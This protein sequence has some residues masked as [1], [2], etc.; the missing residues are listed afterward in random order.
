MWPGVRADRN[1]ATVAGALWVTIKA[2]KA[3]K[4]Q[5]QRKILRHIRDFILGACGVAVK[6]VRQRSQQAY[7][8]TR[9]PPLAAM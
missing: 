3:S 7:L 6:G 9:K 8:D 5:S 1:S 2:E 4:E